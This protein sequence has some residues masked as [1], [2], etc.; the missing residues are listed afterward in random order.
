MSFLHI[1][2]GDHSRLAYG[3]ILADEKKETAVGFW[4]RAHAYFT[5][6]EVTARRVLTDNSSCYKVTSLEQLP[7]PARSFIQATAAVPAPEQRQ[8]RA[9]QPH[10]PRRMG[11][12]EALSVR[13]RMTRRLLTMAPQLQSPPRTHRAQGPT[14]RQPRPQPH[15]SEQLGDRRV[16]GRKPRNVAGRC[17]HQRLGT[18]ART[19]PDQTPSAES[20]VVRA[21]DRV[22]ATGTTTAVP[23]VNSVANRG[24]LAVTSLV[25][26]SAMSSVRGRSAVRGR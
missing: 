5:D 15:G 7:C 25:S 22:G 18:L 24:H 10:P 23:T 6:I 16:G 17:G 11:L 26:S 9:L 13:G 20:G 21:A 1:A 14:T 8:G 3:E 12:H 2:V 19:A 4:P